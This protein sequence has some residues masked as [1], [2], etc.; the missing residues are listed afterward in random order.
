MLVA[1]A[2]SAERSQLLQR[3]TTDPRQSCTPRIK[4]GQKNMT[5]S[6]SFI[7]QSFVLPTELPLSTPPATSGSVSG[8]F[9]HLLCTWTR[10]STLHYHPGWMRGIRMGDIEL[11]RISREMHWKLPKTKPGS[12]HFFKMERKECHQPGLLC[13]GRSEMSSN[14]VMKPN[15]GD[16]LTLQHT[17]SFHPKARA[18]LFRWS[19][20]PSHARMLCLH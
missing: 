6:S 5:E 2:N 17:H 14:N 13:Y 11:P 1:A 20:G 9:Q 18:G 16:P 7:F 3:L 4:G 10:S 12:L 19:E 15:D 8:I